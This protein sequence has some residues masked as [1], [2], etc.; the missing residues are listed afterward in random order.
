MPFQIIHYKEGHEN[1]KFPHFMLKN[2]HTGEIVKKHFR[3]KEGAIG[4]AKNAIRYREKV[5]SKVVGNKILP[6]KKKEDKKKETKPKPK[7]NKNKKK[8]SSY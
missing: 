8:N 5:D 7:K 1:K 4:F 3:D 6:I 2:I